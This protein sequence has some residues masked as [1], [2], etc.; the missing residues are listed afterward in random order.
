MRSR[1][2]RLRWEAFLL[3]AGNASRI[4]DAKGAGRTA[5]VERIRAIQV[6][7]R[8]R[9]WRRAQPLKAEEEAARER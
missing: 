7:V 3:L 8:R 1:A 4:C 6:A 2:H 5:E 9:L